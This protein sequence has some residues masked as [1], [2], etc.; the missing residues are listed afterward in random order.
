MHT[1]I[2]E[3][4]C[5][6]SEILIVPSGNID[7]TGTCYSNARVSAI[8]VFVADGNIRGHP[9]TRPSP[10]KLVPAATNPLPRRMPCHRVESLVWNCH[11]T[12][13]PDT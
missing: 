6:S 1:L 5:L 12:V 13:L 10:G 9:T 3:N 8:T 7:S 4:P 11:L 2:A